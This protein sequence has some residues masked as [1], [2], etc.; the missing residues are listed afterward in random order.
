M[1]KPDTCSEDLSVISVLD[2]GEGGSLYI[3]CVLSHFLAEQT[4][5]YKLRRIFKT[6]K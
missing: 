3:D 6:T 4:W 2:L 5:R 1:E